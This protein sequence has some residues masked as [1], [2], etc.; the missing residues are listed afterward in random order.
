MD[1]VFVGGLSKVAYTVARVRLSW[2][3]F[4]RARERDTETERIQR[5]RQRQREYKGEKRPRYYGALRAAAS[6]YICAF[7]IL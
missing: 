7:H 5:Q 3:A 2:K 4:S 1:F 6:M